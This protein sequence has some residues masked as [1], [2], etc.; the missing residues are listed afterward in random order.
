[1]AIFLPVENNKLIN[2]F[3]KINLND[4]R[5]SKSVLKSD[6]QKMGIGKR[7]NYTTTQKRLLLFKNKI[8]PAKFLPQSSGKAMS[9]KLR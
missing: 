5:E 7:L 2:C 9:S 3:Q 6:K 4:R 8:Q 1:M